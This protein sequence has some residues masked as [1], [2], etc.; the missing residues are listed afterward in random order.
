MNPTQLLAH[1]DRISEAPDA[2]ARL[3]RFILDL[4]VRGKLVE[5]DPSDEPAAELLKRIQAEKTR[6]VKVGAIRKQEQLSEV[7]ASDELF[8]I[9]AS[10]CWVRLS[11]V[12][13]KL[14][15]GTHHSPPNEPEGEF[16]YVTAKNIKPEGISVTNITY[17]SAEVHSEI[18]G[19]CN[20][21]KGDILYIKDGATTGVVTI[22]NL[23]QPFSMLSSVALLKL[24]TCLNNRLVVEFL[25]SPF[26][27]G[28]MRGFMKGAA[29]PRVT[30]K[31]MAP[32][33][34]PLP[35]L[36]EQHRIVAKVDELMAL[37]D[38]LA[39]LPPPKPSRKPKPQPACSTLPAFTSTTCRASAP[40]RNTSSNCAKPSST[41]PSVAASLFKT[42]TTNW[43]RICS[44]DEN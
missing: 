6:L 40:A 25:R 8:K 31:R 33:H 14:T 5:Q 19:R 30:L 34:I 36:A 23:D 11:H 42:P 43:R 29:I 38:E 32:A 3:R 7:N 18:Y 15:D 12:L 37:C 22:N 4:A 21:E 20:P 26:F 9:P 39:L 1:F 17:V 27:Y 16:M 10:W 28:Q 35:P 44:S 24:S 13:T 41:S 2:V